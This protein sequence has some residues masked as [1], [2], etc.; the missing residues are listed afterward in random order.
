MNLMNIKNKEIKIG[1][2][3]DEGLITINWELI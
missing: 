2:I 1:N 3:I